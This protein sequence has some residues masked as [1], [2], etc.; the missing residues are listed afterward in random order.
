MLHLKD[1]ILPF[2][3]ECNDVVISAIINQEW[4]A[5]AFMSRTLKGSEL[6]YYL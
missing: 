6:K 2:E 3:L 4:C 1:D 5:L